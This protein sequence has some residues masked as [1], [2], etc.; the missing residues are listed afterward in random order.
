MLR[1]I[2][3]LAV[4]ACLSACGGEGTPLTGGTSATERGEAN[5]I[6]PARNVQVIC[7]TQK[8]QNAGVTVNITNNCN[9]N[10]ATAEPTVVTE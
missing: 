6:N 8:N 3:V 10:N 4:A 7:E 2:G 9:K 5:A 1:I